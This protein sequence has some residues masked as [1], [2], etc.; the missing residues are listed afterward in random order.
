MSNIATVLKEEISRIARKEIKRETSS[1]KKSSTT[2]RSEIA[3]L[4]R[5]VQE[6]ERQL[7]TSRQGRG[8]VRPSCSERRL[9]LARHSLQR[10]E[11][12]VATAPSRPVGRRMR[13]SHRRIG[14]V[15]LQLGGGQGAPARPAPGGDLCAQEPGTPASERDPG[16]PQSRLARE[17]RAPGPRRVQ[18]LLC[19]TAAAGTPRGIG[20]PS[21]HRSRR[22][23]RQERIYRN[24]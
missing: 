4:K 3:A 22:P 6:L 12:G 10:Q 11:H 19:K 1:L 13:P 9:R 24:V 15:D 21:T 2:H 23:E 18:S 5:R 16:D 14:A 8:A 7:R 20:P 17:L